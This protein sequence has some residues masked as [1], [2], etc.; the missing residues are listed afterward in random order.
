ML[1]KIKSI[2]HC[3]HKNNWIGE[4]KYIEDSI[5]HTFTRIDAGDGYV[6]AKYEITCPICGRV[7]IATK[8]FSFSNDW[9]VQVIKDI[10]KTDK[11]L[12]FVEINSIVEAQIK[13]KN[14]KGYSK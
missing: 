4:Y 1:K 12:D 10:K 2:F 11:D 5:Q 7:D 9:F 3:L 8:I 6:S 13:A 14:F